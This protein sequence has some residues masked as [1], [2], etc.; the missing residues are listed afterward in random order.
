MDFIWTLENPAKATLGDDRLLCWSNW[1]K[2]NNLSNLRWR[3]TDPAR[4]LEYEE[5]CCVAKVRTEAFLEG[6]GAIKTP[7]EFV[8]ATRLRLNTFWTLPDKPHKQ[9]LW[10][11][12]R[13]IREVNSNMEFIMK[14]IGALMPDNR[15]SQILHPSWQLLNQYG[16]VEVDIDH[17][18][19]TTTNPLKAINYLLNKRKHLPALPISIEHHLKDQIPI[20]KLQDLP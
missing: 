20:L 7:Q 6:I 17:K 15:N 19:V 8:F 2:A 1:G 18:T 9:L 16:Q 4:S 12:H 10:H 13:F 14:G 11:A 3:D 5:V